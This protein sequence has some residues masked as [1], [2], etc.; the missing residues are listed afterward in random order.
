MTPELS[1]LV[2]YEGHIGGGARQCA[3]PVRFL[4]E[5]FAGHVVLSPLDVVLARLGTSTLVDKLVELKEVART[6]LKA[7][8]KDAVLANLSKE[9]IPSSKPA[10][11]KVSTICN[12]FVNV[13]FTKTDPPT[14]A[15]NSPH[16]CER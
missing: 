5:Y 3:L 15:S 9:S 1:A 16:R 11:P 6:Q 14:V 7:T 10:E 13:E 12:I 4:G 2:L 8:L